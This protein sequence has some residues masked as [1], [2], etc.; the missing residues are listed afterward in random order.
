MP[1]IVSGMDPKARLEA[2]LAGEQSQRHL[3][4]QQQGA[5]QQQQEMQMRMH[6]QIQQAMHSHKSEQAKSL[7]D[8]NARAQMGDAMAMQQQNMESEASKAPP[9]QKRLE[10]MAGVLSKIQDPKARAFA[11]KEFEGYHKKLIDE[12]ER[13]AAQSVIDTSVADGHLDGEAM[14]ARMDAGEDPK[15]IAREAQKERAKRAEDAVNMQESTDDL[16]QAEALLQSAPRGSASYKRAMNFIQLFKDSPTQQSKAGAGQSL[17]KHVKDA[18]ILSKDEQ[19]QMREQK[20]KTKMPGLGGM[21]MEGMKGELEKEPTMG[22]GGPDIPMDTE[23]PGTHATKGKVRGAGLKARAGAAPD[24]R[25][26]THRLLEES[27]DE[28]DLAKKLKAAGVP[29]TPETQAIVRQAMDE[30]RAAIAGTGN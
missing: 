10:E 24:L 18:L 4:A 14:K 15:V 7:A 21:T 1:R 3:E 9:Q 19:G 25:T 5:R 27:S 6:Q 22:F 8:I 17:L 30:K 28:L 29:L 20:L 13:Q 26:L 23:L 11:A 2:Y 12:E 16:A